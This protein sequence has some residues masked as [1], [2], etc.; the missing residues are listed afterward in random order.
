M[1]NDKLRDTIKNLSKISFNARV[2][3]DRLGVST[4]ASEETALEAGQAADIASLRNEVSTLTQEL[5]RLRDQL[6]DINDAEFT[7]QESANFVANLETSVAGLPHSVVTSVYNAAYFR[8]VPRNIRYL[9]CTVLVNSFTLRNLEPTS[10]WYT[11]LANN[12]S[13]PKE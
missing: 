12:G 8:P 9:I 5:D 11:I 13:F 3:A 6:E 10:L 2:I 4:S 1:M 7:D